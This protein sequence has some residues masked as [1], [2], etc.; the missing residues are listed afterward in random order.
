MVIH[1]STLNVEQLHQLRDTGSKLTWSPQ[2]NLRLYGQT[3]LAAQ[4]ITAGIPVALGAD[5]LPSG[6]SSLLAE[7]KVARRVLA[8][9]GMVTTPADMVRMVTA[10]AAAIAGL[11]DQL[12]SLAT[13]RPADLLVLE[14]HHHDPY[15]NVCRADP[16]WVELVTVGGDITY[17][18]TDWFTR[19]ATATASPT[20]EQ[21]DA[22]GK[23]MTL[24]S[25]LHAP[26]NATTITL[27]NIRKQLTAAYPP[28]GP[29]F[30]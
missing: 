14:R 29:I 25:G 2:S 24:D 21:L 30:A 23:Q 7:M 8:E 15:E 11:A 5:W 28:V 4:A 9:Q 19:L 17:A 18:R 1:G 10:G 27:S 12:G 16:S 22:W 26:P 6:S 3:T 13:G 20:I